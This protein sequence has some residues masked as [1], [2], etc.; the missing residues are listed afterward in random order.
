MNVKIKQLHG[1]QF[2]RETEKLPTFLRSRG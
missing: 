1:I 2:E